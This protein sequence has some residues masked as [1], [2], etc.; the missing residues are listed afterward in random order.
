M[1]N[2]YV[3]GSFITYDF[4]GDQLR[5]KEYGEATAC[6]DCFHLVMFLD[7][8]WIEFECRMRQEIN[9]KEVNRRKE[10][11]DAMRAQK[12]TYIYPQSGSSV[13]VNCTQ[14]NPTFGLVPS[15]LTPEQLNSLINLKNQKR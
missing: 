12:A 15:S 9:L 11:Q 6:L 7:P 1:R 5:S 14:Q 10:Y 13:N 8:D 2:T 4:I 3:N